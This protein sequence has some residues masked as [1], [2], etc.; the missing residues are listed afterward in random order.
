MNKGD[1]DRILAVLWDCRLPSATDATALLD[2][3]IEIL[4]GE[5]N[6]LK[7]RTPI[8]VCGD[9]HGQFYDLLELFLVAG[10][11]PEQN[12]LFWV[13]TSIAVITARRLSF[14]CSR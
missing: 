11:P 1:I 9:I 5:P 7:L 10:K 2:R 6:C 3:S 8:T 14:C 4:R 13:I 12:F